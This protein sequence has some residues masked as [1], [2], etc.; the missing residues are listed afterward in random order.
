MFVTLMQQALKAVCAMKS[1]CRRPRTADCTLVS[2]HM[3]TFNELLLLHLIFPRRP[4]SVSC[5]SLS[6]AL[7]CFQPLIKSFSQKLLKQPVFPAHQRLPRVNRGGLS[8]PIR[9]HD[10][11][12]SGVL[13]MTEQMDCFLSSQA[14]L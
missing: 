6:R 13:S 1:S 7:R 2:C 11:T 5:S 4:V 14:P 9:E 12:N 3:D 10:R 8:Q